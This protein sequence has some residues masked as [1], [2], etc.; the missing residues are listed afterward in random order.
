MGEVG[1]KICYACKRGSRWKQG[2]DGNTPTALEQMLTMASRFGHLGC[3]TESLNEGADVNARHP[4]GHTALMKATQYNN[5]Q[6]VDLLIKA[7]A[8]VNKLHPKGYTALTIASCD[9]HNKCLY[10][11]LKSGADVNIK[12]PIHFT[13]LMKASERGHDRCVKLLIKAGADIN[14][15]LRFP[16]LNKYLQERARNKCVDL[17]TKAGKDIEQKTLVSF[18]ERYVAKRR[19]ESY[20]ATALSIALCE[21]HD[22]CA[23]LL[24]KFGAKVKV[25]CLLES[26]SRGNLS[27]LKKL[28]LK[29]GGNVNGRSKWDVLSPL[30]AAAGHGH[31]ECVDFLIKAEAHVN[32]SHCWDNSTALKYA[33]TAECADLLIKAGAD[34]NYPDY[35]GNT[36]LHSVSPSEHNKFI[37]LLIDSGADVNLCNDE[38]QTALAT[39][40]RRGLSSIVNC[41]IK[42]G[43]NVNNV[44]QFGRTAL[45]Y[46]T[47]YPICL[48]KKDTNEELWN[49]L[50]D[51]VQLPSEYGKYDECAVLLIEAG[52]DVNIKDK[53]GNTPLNDAVASGLDKCVNILIAAGADVNTTNAKG[54][55]V[56]HMVFDPVGPMSVICTGV[57]KS[58]RTVLQ[59]GAKINIRNIHGQKALHFSIF[60][61]VVGK[62]QCSCNGQCRK[63]VAHLLFAAGETVGEIVDYGSPEQRLYLKHICR[64]AIRKHLLKLEPHTHLFGRVPRLGLPSSLSRYLLYCMSLDDD[65]ETNSNEDIDAVLSTVMSALGI[66][67]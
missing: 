13:P 16:E 61:G 20:T 57:I 29:Y 7:G 44:D 10:L 60:K 66:S 55:T 8:D 40:A 5:P 23:D 58:I 22:R 46:F 67:S 49:S 39:A 63:N 65:I 59:A 3:I 15:E 2:S 32:A 54:N 4:L 17:L 38:R 14:Q 64:E 6:C 30:M 31:Y 47:A 35:F 21:G 18:V 45:Q 28:V 9:G 41:L 50:H 12:Y 25:Q 24:L 52:A 11:L 37:N 48:P 27:Y 26:A 53:Y 56:L 34:V 51:L 43:A 62:E 36:A 1:G 42:A 33:A 19:S